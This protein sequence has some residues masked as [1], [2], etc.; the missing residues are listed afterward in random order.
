M[1][2]NLKTE[3]RKFVETL[4]WFANLRRVNSTSQIEKRFASAA[5]VVTP[6]V[7]AFKQLPPSEVLTYRGNGQPHARRLLERVIEA[8]SDFRSIPKLARD[9]S[10]MLGDKVEAVVAFDPKSQRLRVEPQLTGVEACVAYGI[11]L[12]LDTENDALYRV[13]QC[14][15]PGCGR[16]NITWSGK[17][18]W[19]CKGHVDAANNARSAERMREWRERQAKAQK[20]RKKGS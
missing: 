1:A 8:Q 3:E 4:V 10:A 11:A 14:G 2:T 6:R 20:K 18:R 19:H 15:K 7:Q 17:P 9:V 5:A 12:L 13:G 16:F